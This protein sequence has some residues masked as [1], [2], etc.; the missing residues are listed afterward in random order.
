[1]PILNANKRAFSSI[2]ASPKLHN[3]YFEALY[4]HM[5]VVLRTV[6]ILHKIQLFFFHF[7]IWTHSI[8]ILYVY[9]QIR[10]NEGKRDYDFPISFSFYVI[11]FS[12][13]GWLIQRS[14][15]SKK[16]NDRLPWWLYRKSTLGVSL[17]LLIQTAAM[18]LKD[19]WSL[20]KSYD[21]PRQYIKMQRLHLANNDLQVK[22]VVFPV[23]TYGCE[24]WT[25]KKAEC[26]KIDAFELWCWRRLLRVP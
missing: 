1:M 21:K 7:L 4:M 5:Y 20:E 2:A 26:Q 12:V 24:S 11:I 18:E 19:A 6:E 25:I 9:W 17:G 10:R 15:M 13:S 16:G 8:N 14:D 22:A 3:S 23:V